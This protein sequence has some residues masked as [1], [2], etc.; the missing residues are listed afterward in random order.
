[1]FTEI[2]LDFDDFSDAFHATGLMNQPFSQQFLRDDDGVA[3]VK[4]AR[5][6][7]HG[8]RLVKFPV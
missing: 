2:G 6:L 7:L 1:M 8:G 3:V 5:Q 4:W